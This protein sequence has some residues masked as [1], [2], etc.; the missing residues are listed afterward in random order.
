MATHTIAVAG[1]GGVGK[2]TICGMLIDRLTKEKEGPILVVDADA[3]SNL[4]EVLGIEIETTLGAIREEM[5]Q[6]E[7][8]GTIPPGI[9]KQEY[10]ETRFSEALAEENDYDMLVMGRTQG[11]GCYCYVNGVLKSQMDKYVPNYRYVVIDNEAGLEHVSRGTLPHVDT[12]LLVSDC[13]RRG[14]QAVARIAEMVGD[15]ELHP[16][17]MKLIV[18]RAPGGVLN[19]GVQEEIEKHGLELAGVLPQDEQVFEYD[20]EGK[21]TSK[22]PEDSPVKT[23][24]RKIMEDLGL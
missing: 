17:V 24:L 22:L 8:K 12:M 10:A 1:K 16:G 11:K 7:L 13:S 3:N 4:N 19:A 18:N 6:A 23:A 14:I 5:A 20:C 9:T 21:P 2:T 15:L